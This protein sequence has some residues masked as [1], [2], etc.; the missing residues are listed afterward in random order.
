MPYTTVSC[1][2]SHSFRD[3]RTMPYDYG[4]SECQS[5]RAPALRENA[6]WSCVLDS[7]RERY[8]RHNEP[9]W[10]RLKEY[11]ERAVCNVVVMSPFLPFRKIRPALTHHRFGARRAV[12]SRISSGLLFSVGLLK[13]LWNWYGVLYNLETRAGNLKVEQPTVY[14]K[15]KARLQ[16]SCNDPFRTVCCTVKSTSLR[17]WIRRHIKWKHVSSLFDEYISLTV[18]VYDT[19]LNQL[20]DWFLE[21][22]RN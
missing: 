16:S 2:T 12:E 17:R 22:E 1:V 5:V 20:E 8:S 18:K 10:V 3:T 15:I 21:K 4:G 6:F 11:P 19:V 13:E 9:E 7:S 14:R